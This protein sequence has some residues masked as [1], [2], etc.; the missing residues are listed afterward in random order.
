MAVGK[1]AITGDPLVSFNFGVEIS[2]ALTGF[3]TECEGL[4]SET[5]IIEHKVMG[6]KGK[7]FIRKIP[8]RLKWGDIILKR[9]ITTNTDMWEWRQMVVDGDIKGA[10]KDGSIVMYDQDGTEVAR[11]NFEK[12]WPS[13]ISGPAVKADDNAVS[14]EDVTLVHEYIKRVK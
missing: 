5:E 2:G 10:R 14:I 6:D 3:F 11:W 8:G 13:K 7:E 1:D 4:G 12:A 9:G